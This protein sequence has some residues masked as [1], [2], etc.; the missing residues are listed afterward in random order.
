MVRFGVVGTG[1]ICDEFMEAAALIPEFSLAAWYSRDQKR[2]EQSAA[3]YGAGAVIT[4]LE[5]LA[6]SS[7]VD[8]VYIA[9]PNSLHCEQSILM[10]EHGKHVLC[11]KP[12]ASNEEELKRMLAAAADNG[13]VLLE[14]MR[15]V[16]DPGFAMI[17]TLLGRLGTI[18]RA[19]FQYGKY[20]SRY[21]KFRQGQVLNAFNPALSNAAVMDIGVYC[22]HTLVK[23]FGMPKDVQVQSI[24]LENGMEGAGT[25]LADYGAMQAELI[26]S[27]ITDSALPSQIQ[28]EE[29]TMVI[30]EIPD[31]AEILLYPRNGEME[32][33]VID[34]NP[35][36]MVYELLEFISLISENRSAS[37]HNRYSRMEMQLMDAVR[38]K[39]GIRFSEEDP[40]FLHNRKV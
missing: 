28:G 32:R 4:D 6:C 20:S 19:T 22:I 29:G 12:I 31:T 3:K 17:E 40:L 8:A 10:L 26:Y 16:F 39:G 25:I 9:S 11:E 27:K 18:R 14:A 30:R 5:E 13:A 1:F 15:P 34:K 37:G 38:R 2:G 23:L 36:N 7:L 33:F 35:N 24:F 21:D